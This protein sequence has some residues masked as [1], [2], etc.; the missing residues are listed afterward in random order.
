VSLLRQGRSFVLV[1]IAQWL[2]D[3]A[4][5]VALSHVGIGVATA[6]IAG[7]L[8]GAA[9]GFWLNGSVTFSR[10][11]STPGWR[12][13]A[14]YA[15]LWCATTLLSTSAVTA[16]DAARGLRWAWLAKPLVDGLLA[17]GSFLASRHWV[18]R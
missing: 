12:Q 18:Y 11:G 6:N 3:W 1:G 16:I 2:L 5:M 8:S 13:F 10:D 9:L 14:R 7:R 4:V 17:I 15:L